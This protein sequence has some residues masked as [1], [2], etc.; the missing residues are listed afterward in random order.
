MF[1]AEVPVPLAN[2]PS[3]RAC[4]E[5]LGVGS[6]ECVREPLE[7]QHPL[8]LAALLDVAYKP[9][10]VA[11]E[12]ALGREDR[13]ALRSHRRR[14]LVKA[15]QHASDLDHAPWLELAPLEF[16][17]E[18]LGLVVPAHLDQE[19]DR[20]RVLLVGQ[21]DSIARECHPPHAQIQVGR[22]ATVQP[23]LRDA[24][25]PAACRGPVV[26]EVEH[27]RLLELVDEL[28]G[29]EHPRDVRLANLDG[30]R[31]V[32][33]RLRSRQRVSQRVRRRGHRAGGRRRRHDAPAGAGSGWRTGRGGVVC[34][35]ASAKARRTPR[36]LPGSRRARSAHEAR[37]RALPLLP[38]AAALV[39]I[40]WGM[41]R[42]RQRRCHRT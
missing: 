29:Q 16:G 22:E 17:G 12:A 18:R 14:V 15:G 36:R 2:P 38:R 5:R 42:W 4:G 37:A 23:H 26:E 1:G 31:P 27:E 24:Q 30:R 8:D 34:A 32:R 9:V 39:G 25:L 6:H 10:E 19:V 33:I 41:E 3:P 11:L 20:A 21:L 40:R 28:A 35:R 7:A 13:R